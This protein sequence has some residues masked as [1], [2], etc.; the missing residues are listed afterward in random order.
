MCLIIQKPAD[1]QVP[2]EVLITAWENN[3]DGM[4]IMTTRKG[5]VK[6][7]R[8]MPKS[9]EDVIKLYNKFKDE[10]IGIHFRFATH[11]LVN[12]KMAH[13]F[14]IFHNE[15]DGEDLYMMHNGVLRDFGEW[16]QGASDTWHFI[17]EFLQPWLRKYSLE[18]LKEKEFQTMLGSYIGTGNKLLFLD[19]SGS[20]VTIN[21]TMGSTKDGYWIS[22]T[23]SLTPAYR[24][25]AK[26]KAGYWD[27]QSEVG[28]YRDAHLQYNSKISHLYKDEVSFAE[29]NSKMVAE[30][31]GLDWDQD[32]TS[33]YGPVKAGADFK[34]KA[35]WIG[36]KAEDT[37][38]NKAGDVILLP[39]PSNQKN[40]PKINDNSVIEAKVTKLVT[41]ES[42]AEIYEATVESLST[43][44]YAGKTVEEIF[45]MSDGDFWKWFAQH[46]DIAG[47]L[48]EDLMVYYMKETE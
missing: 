25:P 27:D 35:K 32:L 9:P 22:N 10:E 17:N 7:H 46:I 23:Y 30:R 29:F 43:S 3:D 42:L 2:E 31:Y 24:T 47:A 39:G 21:K 20:F 12:K 14:K 28:Y 8:T 38:L 37:T 15:P 48:M 5:R 11:G 16:K 26:E 45:Y 6:V 4:G 34:A 1:I 44:L 13:P 18:I 19:S 33:L 41:P 40:S 36:P